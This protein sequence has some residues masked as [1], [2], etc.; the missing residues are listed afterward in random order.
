MMKISVVVP[1]NNEEDV[2]DE[3]TKRL[4]SSI[5]I[6]TS[7]FEIIFVDDGSVDKTWSKIINGSKLD[8]RIKGIKLSRNFG[9]HYA[10]TAGL[11]NSLGDWIIVMDGDLQDRPEI[12]PKLYE[13]AVEGFDVVFVS[14]ANRKDRSWYL[15]LQKIFY[16]I[17]RILSG[18]RFDSTI[19]NYSIIN[20]K[21]VQAFMQFP[22]NS[23]FYGSTIKWLGF[24]QT[25]IKAD[26]E[27]RFAG[28]ASYTLKT[29]LKLANDIILS[30]SDRPLRF[31]IL[32]G[33][34]VSFSSL[35]CAFWFLYGSLNWGY[36]IVGWPSL[37]ISIFFLGG[38]NLITLGIIG[39]YIGRIFTQVKERPLYVIS[40]KIN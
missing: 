19:A 38:I 31:A 2:I 7:D 34:V 15:L 33:S 16:L 23:R 13:K 30:F 12:I 22:E 29:R 3:L 39:I 9:Q 4:K 18:I 17:L 1:C 24:N 32:L 26:H 10:I 40:E 5:S 6:I 28:H 37:I 20:R 11:H 8:P 14:R 36:S 35:L 27:S 21:V 25:S